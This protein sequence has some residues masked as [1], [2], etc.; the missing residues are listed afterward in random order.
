MPADLVPGAGGDPGRASGLSTNFQIPERSGL[1]SGVRGAGA[2][3]SGFPS[4]VFG[5]PAVARAGHCAKSPEDADAR[6]I[7]AAAKS[8]LRLTGPF[9]EGTHQLTPR[10]HAC[11]S[12]ERLCRPAIECVGVSELGCV[13]NCD[14][15]S[16]SV[17]VI[18]LRPRGIEHADIHGVCASCQARRRS[19]SV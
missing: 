11:Q 1:P 16:R 4:A 13:R 7:A 6:S 14:R 9:I 17:P 2:V 10:R 5:T 18:I 3:R 15:A 8:F 19:P 12:T